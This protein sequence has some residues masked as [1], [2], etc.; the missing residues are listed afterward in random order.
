MSDYFSDD[1]LPLFAKSV[2]GSSVIERTERPSSESASEKR[3][4]VLDLAETG[5]GGMNAL[6]K[7]ERDR[8]QQ[9]EAI[10]DRGV[11]TFMEVGAALKEIRDGRLYRDSHGTFEAY[12]KER[13]GFARNY[14]NKLIESS[15]VAG[16]ISDMGTTVPKTERQA[17][18]VA[19]APEELQTVV[20]ESANEM[21]KERGEP[22]TAKIVQEAREEVVE[23]RPHITNNSGEN[24][25]YT[26]REYIEAARMAM[27]EIDLDPASSDVAQQT[28]KAARYFTAS[29]DGLKQDWRG[30]VWL[31]PPYSRDLVSRF[32]G[33]LAESV[34]A[35]A[36][37]QAVMLTNNATDT[38]WFYSV[39]ELAAAARF[40]R[41][42]VS[43][44]DASGQ[45]KNKPLQGQVVLY[46]GDNA[47]QFVTA[48]SEFGSCFFGVSQFGTNQ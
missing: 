12:C 3:R 34:R 6:A 38:A 10:V 20:W 44:N 41:G 29:D 19:K 11:K 1:T 16:R 30:R 35:E 33:K 23:N 27:G 46:F 45:P 21:A 24:E 31:N 36:V 18:E 25:W 47:L 4:A 39:A 37:T 9:L 8:L 40:L 48:F 42:R 22:V 15:S 32:C 14:A 26:P 17:R 7:R 28:V 43:F 5:V 13:W 2:N